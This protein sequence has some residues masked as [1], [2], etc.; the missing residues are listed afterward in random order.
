LTHGYENVLFHLED[1]AR[2]KKTYGKDLV[3]D[4]RLVGIGSGLASEE[5]YF[6]LV[7]NKLVASGSGTVLDLGCGDGAFLRLV[8]R[9]MP[10]ARGVGID[11]SEDAVRS[12]LEQVEAAGLRSRI[13][14][15]HGDVFQLCGFRRQLEGV[16]A[17]TIFFVLHEFCDTDHHQRAREFLSR[18]RHV[19]PGVRLLI[20]EP[21]RPTAE[22]MRQRPGPG[23]EYFLLHDLSNQHPVDRPGWRRIFQ[24]T[25]FDLI[26]EDYIGL[27]R[28]AIFTIR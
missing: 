22:Q 9:A 20:V 25:G 15:Y 5:F 26:E 21:I 16:D 12:G 13:S 8:C 1:L 2:K 24:D 11:L 4:G 19:L 10:N 14:L 6:P 18:F 17:A 7:L 3:R 23:I 28:T 27:A